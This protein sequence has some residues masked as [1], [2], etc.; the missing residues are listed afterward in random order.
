[1]PIAFIE[2]NRDP[3]PIDHRCIPDIIGGKD[4]P[5]WKAALDLES[6]KSNSR[7]SAVVM[8]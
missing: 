5:G 4:Y 3:S 6:G 8:A 2:E 1:L 7:D